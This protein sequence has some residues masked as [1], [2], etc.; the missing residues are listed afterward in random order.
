M[1]AL[2]ASPNPG[3]FDPAN[4][5]GPLPPRLDPAVWNRILNHVRL[6]NPTLNR[7]WFEQL[8]AR[9][10]DNG[11]IHVT[12]QSVGQLDFLTGP[13]QQ[14]F[15]AAVQAVTNRLNVVLFHCPKVRAGGFIDGFGGYLGQ[16]SDGQGVSLTPD[17]VFEQFITGPDN[18]LAHAASV[19]VADQPGR[20]YNPLFL[21]GGVGLGKTHLLQAICQRLLDKRPDL[22]ILYLSCDAFINQFMNAVESGDM[23]NFRFRYRSADVLVIDDIHFLKGRE[24]TQE[25][26]FHTFNTL[27]Q[28]QK[29]IVLSADA[30]PGEVPELEER[31]VSR[32]NWG[33]VAPLEKPCFETRVAILRSKA[34]LR[35]LTIEDEVLD[36]V[37]SHVEANT[38]ELE[39]VLTKLQGL[40]QLPGKDDAVDANGRVDAKPI[41]LD[42]AKSALGEATSP[43]RSKRLTID[44][45]M[46]AVCEYFG[47]K[48]GDLQGK[49]RPRSIVLPRQLSMYLARK[50]TNFSLEEIGGHFGGR[51]HTTV[52]HAVRTI[53]NLLDTDEEFA[54]QL[55]AVQAK[56]ETA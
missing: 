20:A 33:L 36:Y 55:K 3:N 16:A 1:T 50:N 2:P 43:V 38:R 54:G 7:T 35:G 12:C 34:R 19:A 8:V 32:F 25:E 31:L 53:T 48:V 26:F 9:Q 30:P 39:G 52:L 51:D 49:R 45:I 10:L 21:H 56:L 40:S 13:C 4:V 28:Q 14:A 44:A 47:V 29:Q 5:G 42:L 6:T 24:R 17:Y 15:N 41:T 11:V 37:A 23:N 46:E 22:K 18:R 27:Y